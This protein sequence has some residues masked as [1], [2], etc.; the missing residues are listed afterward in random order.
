MSLE[1]S[2]LAAQ[3]ASAILLASPGLASRRDTEVTRL[4]L[5]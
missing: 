1:A 2:R 4:T 5:S 3:A